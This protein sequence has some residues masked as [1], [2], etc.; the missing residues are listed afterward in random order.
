MLK[1]R[2]EGRKK[3]LVLEKEEPLTKDAQ[4]RREDKI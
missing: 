1:E 4:H 2:R 3:M